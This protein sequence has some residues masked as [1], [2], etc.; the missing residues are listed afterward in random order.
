MWLVSPN[1][2]ES[3]A[4]LSMLWNR[5]CLRSISKGYWSLLV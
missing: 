3:E 2:D 5:L 1:V 4:T